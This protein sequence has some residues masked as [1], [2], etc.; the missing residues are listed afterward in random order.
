LYIY[1][2]YRNR[3]GPL[4]SVTDKY[5]E[6]FSAPS[7]KLMIFN[8]TSTKAQSFECVPYDTLARLNLDWRCVN[9]PIFVIVRS[10]SL[11]DRRFYHSL[12]AWSLIEAVLSIYSKPLTVLATSTD[13]SCIDRCFLYRQVLATTTDAS[14]ANR[15]FLGRQVLLR[16]TGASP[17]NRC[18]LDQQRASACSHV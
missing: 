8:L 2:R 14:S 13:A 18:L 3:V 5:I 15:C 1:D 9:S 11:R 4:R 10:L 6:E 17:A 7:P 16:P 12:R